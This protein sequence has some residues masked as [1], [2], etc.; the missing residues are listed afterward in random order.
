MATSTRVRGAW[1][2]IYFTAKLCVI[3]IRYTDSL[4]A[5]MS[6]EDCEALQELRTACEAFEARK[7]INW[8]G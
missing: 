4:C 5:V 6:V 7:P 8:L 3:L 2:I 1:L